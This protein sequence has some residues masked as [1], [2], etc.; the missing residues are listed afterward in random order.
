MCILVIV[1][2]VTRIL[3]SNNLKQQNGQL[4]NIQTALANKMLSPINS[5]TK[6]GCSEASGLEHISEKSA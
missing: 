4:Q 1:K 2:D 3:L 5:V 6:D